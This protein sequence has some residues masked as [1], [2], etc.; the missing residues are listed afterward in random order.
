MLYNLF[1]SPIELVVDWIF[2][3]MIRQFPF[4]GVLGAIVAVSIAINFL[5]LPIYNVADEIQEKERFLQRKMNGGIERIKAVFHGDERFM[6]L[7]AF[8]KENH[9]SPVFALR[10]S[11]SILIEIPFFIAAY[12]YLSNCEILKES[13]FTITPPHFCIAKI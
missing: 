3:F 5:A 13:V 7:Q 8:Y 9:Y 1:I 4:I 2:L 6:M 11:L 12:H 10:S